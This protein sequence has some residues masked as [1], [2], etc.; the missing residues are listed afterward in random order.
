MSCPTTFAWT[1]FLFSILEAKYFTL[2]YNL[3]TSFLHEDEGD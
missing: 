2:R 1:L 3:I